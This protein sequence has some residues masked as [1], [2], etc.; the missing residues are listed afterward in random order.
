[1]NEVFNTVFSL[2]TVVFSLFITRIVCCIVYHFVV[3]VI[4]FEIQFFLRD[5]VKTWARVVYKMATGYH[6]L[7]TVCIFNLLELLRVYFR[8]QKRHGPK[9][10]AYVF[11]YYIF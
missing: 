2:F 11:G 10:F 6:P 9:L 1:M 4:G 3:S 8:L 7:D 5:C